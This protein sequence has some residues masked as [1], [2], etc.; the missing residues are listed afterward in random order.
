MP[1][2][3]SQQCNLSDEKINDIMKRLNN[4]YNVYEIYIEEELIAI[5]KQ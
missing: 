3:Q 2:Q 4:K 1:K 5:I